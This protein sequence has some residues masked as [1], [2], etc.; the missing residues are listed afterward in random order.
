VAISLSGAARVSAG[1]SHALAGLGTP[2]PLPT[3]TPTS[4]PTVTVTATNSPTRTNTPTATLTSTATLTPTVTPTLTLPDLAPHINAPVSAAPSSTFNYDIRINNLG[5]TAAS[6]VTF[7]SALP[8][9]VTLQSINV[10]TGGF[11]CTPGSGNTVSCTGG[12]VAGLGQA[13]V[14]FSVQVSSICSPPLTHQV[15]VDPFATIAES[16]EAN[17]LAT[18]STSC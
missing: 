18:A 6:S 17:N 10:V 15:T 14:I 11:T 9:Q 1:S 2:P 7:I 4:T 3:T 13:Q 8:V 16:N 5:Q 12:S